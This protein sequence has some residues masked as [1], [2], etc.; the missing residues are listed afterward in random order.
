MAVAPFALAPFT[1]GSSLLLNGI[2]VGSAIG[3]SL[4]GGHGNTP[5]GSSPDPAT[6]L[7]GVTQAQQLGLDAFKTGSPIGQNLI[8]LGTSQMQQPVNYWS[9]ILN[10]NRATMTSAMAPEI[11]R[12]G[13]GYQTALNTSTALNPRGGT[14]AEFNAEMPYQQQNQVSTL[15]QGARPEAAK[16]LFAAGQAT[17]QAGTSVMDSATRSLLG[18]TEAGRAILADEAAKRAAASAQHAAIGRGIFDLIQKFGPMALDR[19]G[20]G[21]K[22]S[23][24]QTTNSNILGNA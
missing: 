23:G 24:N 4:L 16:N 18:S 2:R 14:S 21:D 17:T 12:I 20:G 9:S 15:L 22:A 19:L 10:G 3:T 11:S 7:G 8:G 13:Q 5:T 6:A 1:G